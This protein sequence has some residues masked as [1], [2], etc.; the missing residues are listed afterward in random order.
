M[1]SK[2]NDQGEIPLLR[3]VR[4]LLLPAECDQIVALSEG[5]GRRY[6]RSGRTLDARVEFRILRRSEAAW[7]YERFFETF[8]QE[9]VWGFALSSPGLIRV[10]RYTLGG[11]TAPHTDYDYSSGDFSKI[12]AVVPLVKRSFWSGGN[13]FVGNAGRC[14][15]IGQGDC[16]LFPSIAKHEVTRVTRG[17]RIV[18]TAWM[19]GPP[20]T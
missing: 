14:P 20:L 11:Y 2:S 19:E 8:Q 10:Q 12:T 17:S 1:S 18:L 3:I 7:V 9:N 4:K 5:S 15:L 6:R 16:L 13:L